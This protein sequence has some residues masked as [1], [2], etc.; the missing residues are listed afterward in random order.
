[1]IRRTTRVL[2]AVLRFPLTPIVLAGLLAWDGY[3]IADASSSWATSTIGEWLRPKLGMPGPMFGCGGIVSPDAYIYANAEGRLTLFPRGQVPRLDPEYS[4]W[5]TVYVD[6]WDKETGF[7]ALTRTTRSLSARVES[8][9][10]QS[11][12]TLDW[13]FKVLSEWMTE[14]PDHFACNIKDQETLKS[15]R[16]RTT[17][18]HS[19]IVEWPVEF[20]MQKEYY[21]S[22]KVQESLLLW[23]GVFHNTLAAAALLGLLVSLPWSLC[24]I[25]GRIRRWR[26]KGP[27]RCNTC[28]YDITAV[29]NT[30]T[31]PEC[32]TPVSTETITP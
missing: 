15:L 22:R 11:P 17:I 30:T 3:R 19:E 9:P 26:Y 23:S 28:G 14:F 12:D 24:T 8:P 10:N 5:G 29:P 31:C 25:P 13:C 27:G 6:R 4:S 7:F 18:T 16:D 2:R 32:G 21:E 20:G 1:M